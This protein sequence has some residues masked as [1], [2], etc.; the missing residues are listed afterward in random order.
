MLG[1]DARAC[2]VDLDDHLSLGPLEAHPNRGVRRSVLDRVVDEVHQ[3]LV[4]TAFARHGPRGLVARLH[5]ELDLAV[6]GFGGQPTDHLDHRVLHVDGLDLEAM[7]GR[8]GL[9]ER[10]EIAHQ[11]L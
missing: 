5:D 8:L 11:R 6:I 7:L 9:G 10:R 4:Q 3:D 2:V 1:G